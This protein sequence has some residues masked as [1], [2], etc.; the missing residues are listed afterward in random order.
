LCRN[1][2]GQTVPY[3]PGQRWIDGSFVDDLPAKRLARLYGVNHFVSSMTNPAA[4]AITPDP[5]VRSNLLRQVVSYQARLVKNA[6]TEVLKLSRDNLRF[7]S[8]ALNMLQ[9][10]TYGV[11]A[12]EYTADI[13]IFLR[14]RWNHPLRLL[15]PPSREA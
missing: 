10:L 14:N 5:D 12:Q 6:T 15:A 8:P 11:L 9:H 2:K 1:A 4:L 3:L 7:K 13:N